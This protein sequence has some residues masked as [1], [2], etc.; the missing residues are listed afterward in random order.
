MGYRV[1]QWGTGNVGYHSLRHLIEHPDYELVGLHAH[2]PAKQGKDAGAIAGLDVNTGI[3]ATN[4]AQALLAL[5][6]D[7]VLYNANG[8]NRPEETIADMQSILQSGVNLLSTSMIFLVYPSFA[9]ESLRVPLEQAADKGHATM[10]INGVDPGFSGDVLPLAGLQMA[11][12]V[13]EL[14]VQELVDYSTYEDPEFTGMAFGFGQPESAEPIMSMAGILRSGWGGMVQMMADRVGIKLDEIR[15]SYERCFTDE[16]FDTPM[17]HVPKDSCAA[18]RFRLE[19]MAYGR[20]VI[21]TEHVNRLREDIAPHWPTPP[22]GK[23][24]V[25]RCVLKGN[26]SVTMECFLEGSD[27]DYNTG[28]VQCTALRMINAIPAVCDHAP[29]LISTLDLPYTPSTNF[30]R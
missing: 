22:H 13:Q 16:A 24:G 17:M 3:K 4:D 15:E 7:C 26:P 25:H 19:G 5:R 21:I 18:V 12:N 14:L 23:Q 11:D 2:S 30:V 8:E 28:G 1:V 27:G 10:F 29:G 9:E 20:P 6:P